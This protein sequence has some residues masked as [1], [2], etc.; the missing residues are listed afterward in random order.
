[1]DGTR[2]ATGIPV[3]QR[4]THGDLTRN[5]GMWVVLVAQEADMY[6]FGFAEFG[7]SGSGS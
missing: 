7:G 6:E 3:P 2:R 5:L 4:T 1:M